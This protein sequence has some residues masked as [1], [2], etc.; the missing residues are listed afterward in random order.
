M[1]R[2]R[3]ASGYPD[4]RSRVVRKPLLAALGRLW[5]WL[6]VLSSMVMGW[7]L[8]SLLIQWLSGHRLAGRRS[9]APVAA[10]AREAGGGRQPC[11]LLQDPQPIRAAC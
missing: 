4:S 8:F 10:L 7:L 1:G 5:Q 11:R 2:G 9:S 3:R 6:M